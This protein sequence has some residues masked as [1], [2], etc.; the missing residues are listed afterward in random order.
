MHLLYHPPLPEAPLLPDDPVAA[1]PS[2]HLGNL[3]IPRSVLGIRN[4]RQYK[5]IT[6]RPITLS[7]T[8]SLGNWIVDENWTD[9]LQETHVDEKL[10]AFSN[11]VFEKLN[12][13][14]PLKQVK[15]ACDDPAWMNTR[16]SLYLSKVHI[17]T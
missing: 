1:A 15:I 7:Q 11:L 6:I 3:L 16:L 4:N 13:I 12:D 9:V 5:T 8:N 14:A 10:S 17:E 2:D